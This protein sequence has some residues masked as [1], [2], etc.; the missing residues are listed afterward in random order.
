MVVLGLGKN[1]VR[2]AR[3]W[4]LAADVIA[5]ARTEYAVTEFGNALLDER[6]LDPFLEDIRTLWLIHWNLSTDVQNPLLAWDYLLNRCQEPELVRSAVLKALQKEAE[7]QQSDFS[8][9]TLEQHFDAFLHTYV[10]TRGR[11]GEV[12]EDNLDCPL[13]E[14]EL[15]VRVGEREMD[16][17]A[18]KREP[19]YSFRR[20]EKPDITPEL[21][22]YCLNDFWQKCHAAEGTLPLREVCMAT[23]ALAR[24]SSYQKRTYERGLKLCRDRRAASSLT[25]SLQASNKSVSKENG[26]VSGYSGRFSQRRESMPEKRI[27]DLFNIGN[28]FLRSTHLERDFEDPSA[29]LG[30]VVTDFTRS[31]L[32]R[33]ANGLEPRSGQ[34]AWRMTGDYGAGKSSFALLCALV[35][36]P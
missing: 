15:I 24:F 33:V 3:F 11:K 19:I 5:S 8:L 34:R 2:S 1:M 25:P 10:P 23:A 35:C 28:R 30:Y 29:L 13:V 14:L 36:R 22:V 16:R 32:G 4:A 26:T 18:G 17:S 6:G 21:F 9:V 7:K 27:S 20:E 31:C 12:Q